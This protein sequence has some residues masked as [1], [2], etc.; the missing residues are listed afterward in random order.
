MLKVNLFPRFCL[1][2]VFLKKDFCWFPALT[3]KRKSKPGQNELVLPVVRFNEYLK[4]SQK[5]SQQCKN[6]P[7]NSCKKCLK[8][9]RIVSL[10]QL[11]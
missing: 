9:Q 6:M 11:K 2:V 1:G 7:I 3:E 4:F 10:S 5:S 8:K